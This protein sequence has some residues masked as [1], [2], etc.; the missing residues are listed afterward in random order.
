M[1]KAAVFLL[2]VVFC[3]WVPSTCNHRMDTDFPGA[4]NIFSAGHKESPS[5]LK[6]YPEVSDKPFLGMKIDLNYQN[7]VKELN[8]CWTQSIW[9]RLG[10]YQNKF[11]GKKETYPILTRF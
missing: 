7:L 11:A 10:Y 6:E 3:A 4:P 1:L 9:D 5:H 8:P 2:G